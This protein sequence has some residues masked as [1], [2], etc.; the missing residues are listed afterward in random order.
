MFLLPTAS[1]APASA[2]HALHFLV[3]PCIRTPLHHAVHAPHCV[4]LPVHTHPTPLCRARTNFMMMPRHTTLMCCLRT[5]QP[6]D[7]LSRTPLHDVAHTLP[8]EEAGAREE[9]GLHLL[10]LHAELLEPTHTSLRDKI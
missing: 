1:E 7:R 3:G 5:P 9:R 6:R 10:A 4:L 8:G 2:L